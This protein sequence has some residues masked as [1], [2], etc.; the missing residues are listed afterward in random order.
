MPTAVRQ[1]FPSAG[2]LTSALCLADEN[3]PFFSPRSLAD[4]LRE[5]TVASVSIVARGN[6]PSLTVPGLPT[7]GLILFGEQSQ[8]P[9][10]TLTF[11]LVLDLRVW[12]CVWAN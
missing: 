2:L 8:L 6:A 5:D 10:V 3:S 12:L 9:G 1:S 7:G 4:S 11:P